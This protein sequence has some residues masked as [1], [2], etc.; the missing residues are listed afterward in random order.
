MRSLTQDIFLSTKISDDWAV[1]MLNQQFNR[2]AFSYL[3]CTFDK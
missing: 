1:A 2:L 3:F